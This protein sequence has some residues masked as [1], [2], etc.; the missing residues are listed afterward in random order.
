MATCAHGHAS[1]TADYC[2]QCGAK[3]E[4]PTNVTVAPTTGPLGPPAVAA[5]L[6]CP[7]CESPRTPEEKFCEVCGYDFVAGTL[8]AAPA[9]EPAPAAAP[10][11]PPWQAVVTADREY[12]DG[13]GS[14]DIPFPD[15]CPERV[16]SLGQD[17]IL[18]GRRSES[19]GVHP[20]ID[21]SGAPE[22]T[23]ISR[24]HAILRRRPDGTW[25][26]VDP[27]STNGTLLNNAPL[28]PNVAV[29]LADG[30]RLYL[31]GWTR[32][33]FHAPPATT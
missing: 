15:H 18:I 22:D 17:E 24:A 1:A 31:G 8:P 19:R 10:A 9:P 29:D 2:D 13:N 5:P 12:Y 7:N 16:F 26:V 4:D 6:S 11:L 30:D 28:D 21:L 27:G 32:I 20:Q 3:I 14:D 33:E 25:T 23:G